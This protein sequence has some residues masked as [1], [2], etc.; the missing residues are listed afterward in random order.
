MKTDP[1]HRPNI[2]YLH[3]HDAGRYMQPYGYAIRTPAVQ[4]LAEQGVLFRQAFSTAPTCSPSRASLVTGQWAHC[5]GMLGLAHRGFSLKDYSHH[6]ARVLRG[7]G[8]EA[9]LS[10]F[11]HV[12]RAPQ[13]DPRDTGYE[14][15]TDDE[16]FESVTAAAERFLEGPREKPFFLSVGYLAPHRRREDFH[17]MYPP[18]DDRYLRPPDPLPDTPETRKDMALYHASVRSTDTCMGRVLAALDRTGLADHTLVICT[19]DHGIAFPEM[20]SNLTD[21]GIGVM[22]IMRGPGGFTGGKVIDGMVSQID[23]F[24]TLCEMVG[25]DT[26]DW[27]QGRSVMP[28]VRGEAEEINDAVFAE[29]SYHAAYEPA[30]CVRTKRWK[31]IRR[32]D[33]RTRPVL[34]NLDDGP[35]KAQW[36]R[37]G[38]HER[39]V[40]EEMLF[41]LVFDPQERCNLIASPG[42]EE[43]A[44]EMR[45]RLDDWMRETDDPLLKGPIPAP[46]GARVSDPDDYSPSG[47]WPEELRIGEWPGGGEG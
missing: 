25:I 38:W 8:Y 13:A 47:G 34:S 6:I 1:N 35:S 30:R 7:A 40:Q 14:F 42:L 29:I 36:V 33:G 19:T 27:L 26:P 16:S 9:A 3:C 31:Y 10:G 21:H 11:Q 28:L 32:F 46:A 12:A 2:L 44:A 23:L 45:G 43:V 39:P 15:L 41:D 18:E 37:H 17:T 20:K 4:A 22:L 24:P 5:S